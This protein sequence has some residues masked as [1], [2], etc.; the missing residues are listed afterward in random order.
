M[1]IVFCI[2]LSAVLSLISMPIIISI[3]KRLKLYDY[4]DERKI[5][6]GDIPRLGGVGIVISFVISSLLYL[7][8]NNN[9]NALDHLPIYIAAGIIFVFAIVDDILNL[10]AIVN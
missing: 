9:I 3:C 8:T 10:P 2:G 1:N 6:S 7:L 5:H 4:H